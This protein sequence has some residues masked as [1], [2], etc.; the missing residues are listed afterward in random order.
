M[1]A[2]TRTGREVCMPC[3]RPNTILSIYA[4]HWLREVTGR[5]MTLPRDVAVFFLN[6]LGDHL[7]LLPALRALECAFQERLHYFGQAEGIRLLRRELPEMTCTAVPWVR[8]PRGYQFDQAAIAPKLRPFDLLVCFTPWQ[9]ESL[10]VLLREAA[11]GATL[12][13]TP[14]CRTVIDYRPGEHTIDRNFRVVTELLPDLALQDYAAPPRSRGLGGGRPEVPVDRRPRRVL[15][16]HNETL[17]HK[18]WPRPRLRRTLEHFLARHPDWGVIGVGRRNRDLDR[19]HPAGPRGRARA[20]RLENA[21]RTV[22]AADAF[23]G[24]DSCMLHLADLHRVPAVGLFGPPER[25]PLGARAMGL[26][27]THHRHVSGSGSMR[28]IGHREVEAA[29]EWLVRTRAPPLALR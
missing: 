14:S 24:V 4:A 20:L 19:M 21:F 5:T 26:R 1:F 22:A 7:M 3:P 13:L 8:G 25:D 10:A 11:A 23:L 29:L 15:A 18:V 2:S 28:D 16:V 27:F 6:G 12:G 9:D 17:P